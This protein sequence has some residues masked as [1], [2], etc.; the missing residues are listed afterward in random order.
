MEKTGHGLILGKF[1]PPH[2]GHQYLV[3]FA[4]GFVERLT[5]LVCSI[6]R[7]PLP[8]RLRYEWMQ[9]LFPQAR[10]I[11]VTDELPQEP[12]EHPRF[13]DLWR[14]T[15][16][17]TAGEPI[18]YIFASENYG[19]RL[20][21]EVGATFIPV[22]PGREL[23]PI[24]GT[25]IR[26]RPLENW[27][28]I[29]ECVRPYFVKRVCIFGPESTGKSTLARDLAANFGTVYVSEFARGLLDR[30]QGVCDEGDIPLIARGQ[31]AAEDALARRAN[32]ILFCDTDLLT[33]TIWSDVLFGRCP[34]WIRQAALERKYDLYLLL[35]VDVP[36]VDDSQR[37]LP[38]A[39]AEFFQR[40]CAALDATQRPYRIIR[41]NWSER[42]TQACNEVRKLLDASS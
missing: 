2:A 16:L 19:Q 24:S 32:K 42:F 3:H 22:D 39:R 14:E 10:V 1:M 21:T 34:E 37:Y 30:K 12:I 36:W 35:D 27:Q 28:Y 9:E 23:V 38:H 7:E 33:T 31:A 11:H 13:W 8:G 6:V 5:V 25:A 29:P 18:D 41:G 26:A 40:C 17:K 4:Q 15:V 20:A